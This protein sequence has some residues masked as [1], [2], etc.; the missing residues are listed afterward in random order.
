L[1]ALRPNWSLQQVEEFLRQHNSN[2]NNAALALIDEHSMPVVEPIMPVVEPIMPIEEKDVI[3]AMDIAATKM[4]QLR[5][6]RMVDF[7]PDK[8]TQ[9]FPNVENGNCCPGALAQI[10]HLVADIP[11]GRR[12]AEMEAYAASMRETIFHYQLLNFDR[13]CM[14]TK[15]PWH[16]MIAMSHNIGITQSETLDYGVWPD[17]VEG[18][19]GKWLEERDSFFFTTSEIMA[20]YEMMVVKKAQIVIR[21]W[22]QNTSNGN[23][24][25][26]Y[27]I[28]ETHNLNNIVF[29]LKH[30]GKNDSAR[31]HYELLR[32]G[33]VNFYKRSA[34]INYE[35][36][37]YSE[38]GKRRKSGKR[39]MCG[40]KRK[41]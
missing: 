32:S 22:R 29:D 14:V 23:L 1:R 18:R 7:K 39:P 24:I 36:M 12:V 19:M 11:L 37:D 28:P 8:N 34:P 15:Q 26:L 30:T 5:A 25:M 9:V 6:I 2:A 38:E 16:E 35:D 3:S 40:G 27:N 10:L 17:S 13:V 21:V 20:F 31:A 4:T 33:S 41:K